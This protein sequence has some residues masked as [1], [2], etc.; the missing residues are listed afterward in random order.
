MEEGVVE[1]LAEGED[2]DLEL[3]ADRVDQRRVPRLR[4]QQLA[5]GVDDVVEEVDIGPRVV[6]ADDRRPRQRRAPEGEEVLRDVVEQDAD[7]QRLVGAAY[8]S[9][10]GCGST[11]IA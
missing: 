10:V 1:V 4:D 9:G 8:D 6:D 2:G 7:V 3:V 5:V 11:A